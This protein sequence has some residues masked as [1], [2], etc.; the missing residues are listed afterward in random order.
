MEEEGTERVL[1]LEEQK[2]Y[3]EIVSQKMR[4]KLHPR[5]FNDMTS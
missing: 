5:Y 1:E 4:E 2:V 3:S